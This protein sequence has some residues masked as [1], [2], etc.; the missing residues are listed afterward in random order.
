MRKKHI[1]KIVHMVLMQVVVLVIITLKMIC[2][3]FNNNSNLFRKLRQLLHPQ[4]LLLHLFALLLP[5]PLPPLP[6]PLRLY[7]S[8]CFLILYQRLLSTTHLLLYPVHYYWLIVT[9]HLYLLVAIITTITA[10]A[11][12]A[13]LHLCFCVNPV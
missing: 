11:V 8:H 13:H 12:V 1:V 10:A 5:P 4:L 7:Y 9:I 6:L 3:H 2:R